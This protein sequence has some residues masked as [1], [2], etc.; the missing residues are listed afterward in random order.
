MELCPVRGE[1][2]RACIAAGVLFLSIQPAFG[3]LAPEP[4][5]T[6][7]LGNCQL[8]IYKAY[9][10]LNGLRNP[11]LF[12][13][14]LDLYNDQNWEELYTLFNQQNLIEDLRQYGRDVI[15]LNFD[16][17][18]ERIWDSRGYVQDAIDYIHQHFP[19]TAGANSFSVIGTGLGGLTTRLA[20]A[21]MENKGESHQVDTWI[22]FDAPHEGANIPLG[23]QKAADFLRQFKADFTNCVPFENLVKA[24][25]TDAAKAMLMVLH[26]KSDDGKEAGYDGKK[27]NELI[28]QLSQ[29]GYPSQCKSVAICNGSGLG[30]KQPF[31][32]GDPVIHWE[33]PALPMIDA[34][35]Y[36]L[37]QSSGDPAF[38]AEQIVFDG[39][40][41]VDAGDGKETIDH[42]YYPLSLD[43][44]PGGTWDLFSQLY[45]ILSTFDGS[46][47]LVNS[48]HCF[49]PTVSALG[50][51]IES[52]DID[53]ST[54]PDILALS[55]FDEVHTALGNEKHTE[56]NAGN[57][58]WF[59][60]AILEGFD[61]DQDG[62]DDYQQYLSGAGYGVGGSAEPSE[63]IRGDH[64]RLYI[65]KAYNNL[66]NLRNPVLFVEGFDLYNDQNWEELYNQFNQ[67]NLID[68][69][70]Q[71]GRDVIIMNFDDATTKVWDSRGYVKSTIQ[72][73]NDNRSSLTDKFTII[74][75]SMGGLASRLAL[76]EMEDKG[77]SHYV[78]TWISFDAPHEGANV[79]LGLQMFADFFKQFINVAPEFQPMADLLDVLNTDAAEGMLLV[80][81]TKANGLCGQ[82]NPRSD[83]ID[84]CEQFGYPVNCKSIA[85]SNGSGLG[86]KQPF[87]AGDKIIQ[88][89]NPLLPWIDTSVYALPV[90]ANRPVFDGL[91]YIFSGKTVL[92]KAYYTYSLDNAPGGTW[93]TFG[94]IY[95][96]LDYID[97]D[98]FL[99]HRDHCFVPTVSSLG[100]PLEFIDTDLSANPDVL[101]LSPF[102]EIHTALDNEMHTE[103]NSRNKR[104]FMRGVLEGIDSD[105]D[106]LSDYQE[107]LI[108]TA[109][110]VADSDLRVQTTVAP[111]SSTGTK[112][113]L[114]DAQGDAIADLGD[115]VAVS[116]NALQNV[117]YTI[118][119]TDSLEN[120]WQ[121]WDTV[122]PTNLSTVM[123]IYN[124]TNAAGFFTTTGTIID[125]VTD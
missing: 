75:V 22:S 108:G 71:Y 16:D 98:D 60:R 96:M 53:L 31:N 4:T 82:T 47:F 5:E 95:D 88:W 36:A 56:I 116:Y 99:V 61:T 10:N 87:E 65:Y 62:V 125:P 42:S 3:Q 17:A 58:P 93:D 35:V 92:K 89:K 79:P 94:Q 11:V 51:P 7:D 124:L 38:D 123:N 118:W 74:G 54:N 49:V 101:A 26:S 81:Y 9:N 114:P 97:G 52:L 110:N 86:E 109:Y 23:V 113:I 91:F 40:F 6:V 64:C 20:L 80:H 106:G 37:P 14:D 55:P 78:D 24:L 120:P 2:W 59:M 68:D 107:Y 39:K 111:A 30:E 121:P 34:N 57:K 66:R 45:D 72:Y 73:I 117:Q 41:Y 19:E 77:D 115:A 85:I 13:E 33:N 83:L 122:P 69:L 12:V 100:I 44:A 102:D 90:V 103:I 119:F 25:N 67:E 29:Q 46:G 50:I 76:A 1:K 112:I 28:N 43:N 48:N 70:R 105:N 32:A 8:Y 15:I 27:R 84:K 63:I 18:T 21:E 104:W